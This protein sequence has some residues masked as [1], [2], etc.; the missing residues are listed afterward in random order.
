[1]NRFFYTV[2]LIFLFSFFILYSPKT[3]DLSN[4]V[5][6]HQQLL[7][8][9]QKEEERCD[10]FSGYWVQ[11]LR[12][13]QYT[14]VSCSSIPESKNCFMQGRPDA[15]FS[16]WR[17]KPDGCELPRFD[18][19]TFFEIV[20]GKTMAFIGDSVA[21]NHVESLLC[22]LS[23]EEMPLGIYKDT[24]DRTR[25]WYFPHSNF[26]LMV[27]WTRFL[28]LDEERVINGS[29]TG[30]FDLHLDKMDKNWA[31]KL[32]EID[33]AILSD[34]HWFFRKNYLYEKGKNIGCIFCGEPGIKSLDIDSAL[35]MVIKVVLN[36]IN[37]CKKCRN[38]LTVLRTFSPAHFAD[39]AWDTGGS[40]NRTHPLGEKEIDLASLDW[41]IRSIQVEEIKRVRP[42]ARRRKKFEVLDVTKAM[43][44]RPD[45]HPNSYWGNKWMKGYNDC[46][47]WCMPGPIDAWND[48][49][50]ALLRRHAFTDFTWA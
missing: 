38:I 50:I 34:A 25:T 4:N 30:V 7:I 41:K 26:T 18:P 15:G 17:W 22:L 47:H 23:S 32:P 3:S 49:L 5:D 1:M 43:L 19:G 27:I 46:V 40:C 45:G 6:L 12:G 29:V 48:F 31:N 20:R 24:E 44:M 28:V 9:L 42:V 13:S 16:Q 36:Y 37:N 35:Q 33:Y 39:G 11:D 8:S 10:L 14:N 2:G 21:R